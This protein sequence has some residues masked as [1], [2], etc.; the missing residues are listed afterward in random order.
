MG[1]RVNSGI[2]TIWEEGEAG[3]ELV[4]DYLKD[5]DMV[6]EDGIKMVC[7]HVTKS[8]KESPMSQIGLKRWEKIVRHAE[9]LGIVVALENTVWPGYLEFIVGNIKSDNL[10]VCYDSGHAH[11]H[12]K[13]EYNF[14]AF[15]NK[16]A[17][18]HLHDND[19]SADQHKLP[20]DGTID[21]DGLLTHLKEANFEGDFT[22]EAVRHECYKDISPLKFFKLQK[23]RLEKLQDLYNS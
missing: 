16:I 19:A 7:M 6:A 9:K 8:N 5:L 23:E 10:A 18:L 3:D 17:C 2:A 21:W 22:S 11:F 20:F 14:D 1:Y 12:F 4:A 15:K 13:D